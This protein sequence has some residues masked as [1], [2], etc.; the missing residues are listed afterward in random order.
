MIEKLLKISFLKIILN[1]FRI[2]IDN[3]E[4]SK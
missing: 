4:I 2:I 1:N 3:W